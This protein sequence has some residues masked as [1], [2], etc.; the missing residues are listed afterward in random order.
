VS[1]VLTLVGGYVFRESLIEAGK[2]SARDPRVAFIQ[3]E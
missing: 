3:P 2:A 1:S